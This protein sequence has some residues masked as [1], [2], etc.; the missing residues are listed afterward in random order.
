M[1]TFSKQ[2][3]YLKFLGGGFNRTLSINA[4]HK[5][6]AKN[7]ATKNLVVGGWVGGWVA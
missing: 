1:S 2:K 4:Q 6:V 7:L 5:N 3:C